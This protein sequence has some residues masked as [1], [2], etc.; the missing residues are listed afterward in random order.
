[1]DP[2]HRDAPRSPAASHDH[3]P[4]AGRHQGRQSQAPCQSSALYDGKVYLIPAG[5][6]YGIPFYSAGGL[7]PFFMHPD[8]LKPIEFLH[9]LHAEGLMD[10]DFA[11]IPGMSSF[12]QFVFAVVGGPDGKSGWPQ[13]R[14]TTGWSVTS[15]SRVPDAAV[16]KKENPGK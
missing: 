15:K 6:A 2:R 9:R 3:Q 16:Y 10:T 14:I 7:L 1:M 11:T 4:D 5:I 13:E 12:E 8:F